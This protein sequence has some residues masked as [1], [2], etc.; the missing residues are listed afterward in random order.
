MRLALTQ[1]PSAYCTIRRPCT[2]ANSACKTRSRTQ[3]QC[4]TDGKTWCRQSSYVTSAAA[5]NCSAR[6]SGD[7]GEQGDSPE[8]QSQ[9]LRLSLGS[10]GQPWIPAEAAAGL[11][12]SANPSPPR[13]SLVSCS[14]AATGKR[15]SNSGGA[16]IRL[17]WPAFISSSC[18]GAFVRGLVNDPY[19]TPAVFSVAA[20]GCPAHGLAIEA[21][22]HTLPPHCPAHVLKTHPIGWQ[23]GTGTRT[24][25]NELPMSGAVRAALGDAHCG[26]LSTSK[27]LPE[28]SPH[29][30]TL[31][32][33]DSLSCS[34]APRSASA[35]GP[36][37]LAPC[38]CARRRRRRDL[39]FVLTSSATMRI[40]F[41]SGEAP[42]DDDSSGRPALASSDPSSC[43][44]E[45]VGLVAL[46]A[47]P[48]AGD[49]PSEDDTAVVS[50]DAASADLVLLALAPAS[51][52]QISGFL[53]NAKGASNRTSWGSPCSAGAGIV[54]SSTNAGICLADA[55]S[56]FAFSWSS[57]MD[58]TLASSG[59]AWP[60]EGPDAAA[61]LALP[62]R[63]ISRYVGRRAACPGATAATHV[64]LSKLP[65]ALR[66]SE[67]ATSGTTA[68]MPL[69][70]AEVWLLPIR[71]TG[72]RT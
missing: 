29:V 37:C 44:S 27:S 61:A 69:A 45:A 12:N 67:L 51:E 10:T 28:R 19:T 59:A 40:S 9:D 7:P 48:P 21:V 49:V 2:F 66:S 38:F 4:Q 36:A 70:S 62:A 1:A 55:T 60:G 58:S 5:R 68:G 39:E 46:D 54:F 13:R 72:T 43:P 47:S 63:R 34:M 41:P 24:T 16:A 3:A 17:P 31:R 15:L 56:P 64:P 26:G 18:G 6:S 25:G 53:A 35:V 32:S 8:A 33:R 22:L 42:S 57:L 14:A 30:T 11:G 65:C 20:A 50:D 52:T 23:T 71:L